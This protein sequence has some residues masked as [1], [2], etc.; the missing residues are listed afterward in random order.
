MTF[1]IVETGAGTTRQ[2]LTHAPEIMMVAFTFETDSEGALHSHPHLQSTYVKS[3][4][5][6]FTLGDETREIGPGESLTVP[7]GVTHGCVC[8]EAGVLIDAF[9]PRRDDFL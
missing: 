9:S 3:G 5:F 6:R 8:L 7:S 4:R 2:V 1:P